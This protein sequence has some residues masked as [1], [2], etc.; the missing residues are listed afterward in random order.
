MHFLVLAS[1]NSSRGNSWTQ[2]SQP[3]FGTLTKYHKGK[4]RTRSK[5]EEQ[6][7]SPVS[8]GLTHELTW[9]RISPVAHVQK[10]TG[11]CCLSCPRKLVYVLKGL[12]S[13]TV[14]LHGSATEARSQLSRQLCSQPH[15]TALESHCL[16][17][18]VAHSSCHLGSLCLPFHLHNL[19]IYPF[20]AQSLP[21]SHYS[22]LFSS[23][24]YTGV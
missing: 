18:P 4:G 14:E 6:F 16:P 13:R 12:L 19:S 2:G 7:I 23:Q 5:I 3:E 10:Q 1:A 17:V 8:L 21:P 9:L 15:S 24:G 22:C 11:R 20:E